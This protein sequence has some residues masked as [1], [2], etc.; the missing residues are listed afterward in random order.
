MSEKLKLNIQPKHP[1]IS[2]SVFVDLQ[3]AIWFVL[4]LPIN[5]HTFKEYIL[6]NIY[7]KGI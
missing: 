5:I 7:L 3:K 6:R 4:I 1:Q 2:G